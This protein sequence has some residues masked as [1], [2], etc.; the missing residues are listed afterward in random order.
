MPVEIIPQLIDF[1]RK[2]LTVGFSIIGSENGIAKIKTT[3]KKGVIIYNLKLAQSDN[4]IDQK[5]AAFT[6]KNL[7][8]SQFPVI[9]EVTDI[10]GEKYSSAKVFPSPTDPEVQDSDDIIKLPLRAID[11]KL[12]PVIRNLKHQAGKEITARKR[13]LAQAKSFNQRH[14]SLRSLLVVFTI[15]AAIIS[16]TALLLSSLKSN[17]NIQLMFCLIATI[18]TVLAALILLLKITKIG[19]TL[20]ALAVERKEQMMDGNSARKTLLQYGLAFDS[21]THS[22][23]GCG[24]NSGGAK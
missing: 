13:S 4:G 6:L 2:H 22:G 20:N 12:D 7:L 24:G 9:V 5:I 18:V 19:N 15:F 1:T 14:K 3:D 23:C 11:I 21:K 10:K 16:F 8:R 17:A